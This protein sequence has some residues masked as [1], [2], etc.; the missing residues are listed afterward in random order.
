MVR[1]AQRNSTAI[2]HREVVGRILSLI[3]FPY[4]VVEIDRDGATLLVVID[5]VSGVIAQRAAPRSLY[6]ILDRRE[7]GEPAVL[8][9]RPLCCPNC[10]ADLPMNP[11]DVVF[12]CSVCGRAWQLEGNQMSRVPHRIATAEARAA[13]RGDFLPFWVLDQANGR[14]FFIPA[15][16]Y[17]GLEALYRMAARLSAENPSFADVQTKAADARGCYYDQEDAMRLARFAYRAGELAKNPGEPETSSEFPVLSAT[18]VWFEF[19]RRGE[20]L[21]DPFAG[22]MLY[23]NALR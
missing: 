21:L 4:W 1:G 13:S 15:F 22:L 23:A 16:K 11:D 12:L 8:G 7:D 14:R 3:Y 18:L 17:R 10:R 5:G 9:F 6:D 19:E 2:L 20:M